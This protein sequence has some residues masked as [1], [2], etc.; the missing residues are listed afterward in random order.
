M[1]SILLASASVLAFAGVAAAEVEFSGEATMGYNDDAY[2]DNDGF[3]WD[4]EIA[5]TLSQ[6]LD[7]GL[8]AGASF[9]F[10]IADGNLGENL[11]AGGYE[12]F[13]ESDTAGLYFGDTAFAAET[14]WESA[15]SMDADNFSEADGETALRGEVTFGSVEAAVSYVIADNAGNMNVADD[16]NQLSL[17]VSA[18]FGA[19]NVVLAYQEASGEAAGFY[20]NELLVDPDGIPANGDEFTTGDNGDFNDNEVFGISF[21]GSVAG[22]D[23]RVGYADNSVTDSLGVEVSYPFGPVTATV[24][25]VSEGSGNDNYGVNVAYEDGPISAELDYVNDAGNDEIALEGSYDVG[26]GLVVYAGYLTDESFADDAFYVG[27]EFDLG[28]GASVLVSYG[29]DNSNLGEDEI[30]AQEYQ[31]GVTV[32][33]AFEF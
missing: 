5:V 31:K 18:D 23:F 21:G 4:A 16:L 2:G 25:Y 17:G 7:N 11:E 10:D 9:D 30:G 20:G 12:L 29:D 28:G 27:G 14:L 1:K 13:L 8:T 32:E 33:A 3:Y 22:A 6:E 15:G 26:N 19:Y 24:Y